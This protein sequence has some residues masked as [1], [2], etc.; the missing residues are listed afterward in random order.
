MPGQSKYCA[1]VCAAL[2]ALLLASGTVEA[3]QP[4]PALQA[5]SSD[6]ARIAARLAQGP[7]RIIVHHRAPATPAFAAR[8]TAS[9]NVTAISRDLAAVQDALIGRHIGARPG[10]ALR[11]MEVTP[12]FAATVT[13]AEL[14]SLSN[15]SAVVGIALDEIRDPV[16][17]QSVPLIGMTAAYANDNATGAGWAVAIIDSG[18]DKTHTFLQNVIAEACYSTTTGALGSG[19]SASTC[20]GGTASSTA[21]GSGVNCNIAWSGCEHGTHVAGI[22]A[23]FNTQFQA[24]QPPNGVAKSAGIIAIKA[25]SEF[26]GSDCGPAGSPSPCVRFWDSDMMAAL[27]HVYAIRNSLPAGYSGVAAANLSIGGGLF[28][29]ACDTGFDHPVF[30][31]SIANLL[32]ANIATVIAAGNSGQTNAI[33]FPACISSAIAVAASSKADTIAS[34]TNISSQVAVFAPGGNFSASAASIILSSVPAGYTTCAHDGAAYPGPNPSSGGSYCYLAGTSMATP[35]VAG[36]FAAIRSAVP[37]ATVAQ[38]LAALKST[39]KLISDNRVGG[40]VTKPRINVDLAL[41]AL[42]LPGPALQLSPSTG[43][44]ASGNPGGPFSPTSFAYTVSSPIGSVDYSITGVPSWLTAS[45]TSGTATTSPTTITFTLNANANT[46]LAGNYRPTITFTNLTNGFGTQ[47]VSAS[48]TVNGTMLVVG[49]AIT[50][51]GTQ[52]GSFIPA[53][54]QFSLFNPWTNNDFSISGLPTWLTASQT[55][56]TVNGAVGTTVTLALNASA[57]TLAP[58]TYVATISFTNTTSGLGNDTRTATLVVNPPPLGGVPQPNNT[59]VDA[60]SGSDSGT[61]PVAAPCRSLAYALTQTNPAGTVTILTGGTFSSLFIQRPVTIVGPANASAVI[62]SNG[63]QPAVEIAAG[64]TDTIELKN[65]TLDSGI[66]GANALKIGNAFAVKLSGVT[67]GGTINSQ[68]MLVAPSTNQLFRL[69]V[70]DSDIGVGT[71][72]NGLLVQPGGAT[73]AEVFITNSRFNRGQFGMLLDATQVAGSSAGVQATIDATE[74]FSDSIALKALAP[75]PGFSRAA[76]SRSSMTN[77]G[78]AAIVADGANAVVTLYK[79]VV[80]ANAIGVNMLNGGTIYSF[81]NNQIYKNGTDVS[82]GSLV[83]SG[84]Q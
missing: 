17:I 52:G 49:G 21:A 63:G 61:C 4:S 39:G 2:V 67:A 66:F 13:A 56:G 70:S 62:S 80:T 41:Q 27:D 11:R 53:S 38:I 40:T 58:G 31:V 82:G 3:Q 48:L 77:A 64:V 9:E 19:G 54:F 22:A 68:L 28:L 25:A 55:S 65:I 50:A 1:A 23:G 81:G 34:Y 42:G 44:A 12:A 78:T 10:A 76:V 51:S 84:H 32:S 20:P 37:N 72:S 24:G 71:G 5:K 29:G 45:A 60:K 16:L 7:V 26:T 75:G 47:G 30:K 14:E 8:G 83:S 43:I 46:L 18:V 74:L 79:D 6:A 36:A 69:F 15:D 57:S 59:W 35:H 73:L 33:S